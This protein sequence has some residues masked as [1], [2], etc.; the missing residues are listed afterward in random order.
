M[1]GSMKMQIFMEEHVDKEVF[2]KEIGVGTKKNNIFSYFWCETVPEFWTYLKKTHIEEKWKNR[3]DHLLA[4]PYCSKPQKL[5]GLLF[6]PL[7]EFKEETQPYSFKPSI[8]DLADQPSLPPPRFLPQP[9]LPSG[10]DVDGQDQKVQK[11][12]SASTILC[13]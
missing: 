12:K 4:N 5:H 9:S 7:R 3:V 11:H 8:F 2:F 10:N 6:A 13:S 1:M